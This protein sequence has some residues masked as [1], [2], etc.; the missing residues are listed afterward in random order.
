MSTYENSRKTLEKIRQEF[1]C[2][3]EIIFRTAILYVVEFGQRT[4]EDE[5]FMQLQFDRIDAKHDTAEA[6]GKS[7]YVGRHIEKACF[8]CA[9]KIAMVDTCHL[10]IY[11][12]K[13]LWVGEEG[14]LPY[15]RAIELLKGCMS[16]I[17][18]W[19]DC[20]CELTF[21][22]FEDIGFGEEE[23]GELGFGYV[24]NIIEEEEN[25]D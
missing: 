10:I 17:E 22:E 21:H 5:E 25:N 15:K 2:K 24:L 23:I 19:N 16:N 9:A 12:Q 8:E 11:I 4:F 18:M 13:E 14:G 20:Q 7:L 3:G 6:E 1:G